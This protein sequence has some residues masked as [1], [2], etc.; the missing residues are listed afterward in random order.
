MKHFVR[1]TDI[2]LPAMRE[3][4]AVADSIDRYHNALDGKS[5]VL[6]FPDS[7][8][9]TRVTFEKGIALLGGQPILFHPDALD[10]K[11]AT[12]DVIGYLGNWADCLIIRHQRLALLDEIA[13]HSRVPLINA[14]TSENHPCEVLSDLYALSK[15]RQD[16]LAL[17]YTFVGSGG[18][19][20]MAWL[21][22]ARAFHLNFR[23]CC[24]KGYEMDGA[25][26]VHEL[27]DAMRG[28]DVIITDSL[29][30]TAVGDFS[31]YQITPDALSRANEGAL[32]NPCPPFY[33][34]EEVSSEAI[35]SAHFVGYDFKKALLPIQ[36]ALMIFVQGDAKR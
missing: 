1:L 32:L 22:A 35:D 29:P 17:H 31:P 28:S 8:I 25:T 23:Q 16:F 20:G 34:G 2:S 13:A 12:R 33:R 14:M 21:E 6:F 36:Q 11:E 10:K 3:I 26:I 5:V 24:P 18:N 9:R 19:I 15:R 7:S 27:D 30:P 4:F